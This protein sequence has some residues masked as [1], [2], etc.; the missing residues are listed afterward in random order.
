MKAILCMLL[1][2]CYPHPWLGAEGSGLGIV[3]TTFQSSL[4]N[5]FARNFRSNGMHPLD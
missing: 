1:S 2:L 3:L 5:F 4:P